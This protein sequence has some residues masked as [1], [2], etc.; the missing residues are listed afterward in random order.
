MPLHCGCPFR[1]ESL[2]GLFRPD[3]LPNAHGFAVEPRKNQGSDGGGLR[4]CGR[5][6]DSVTLLP[7]SKGQPPDMVR[8]AAELGLNVFG[9]NRVQ[10]AKAR[11]PCVPT[12][13]VGI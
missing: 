11:S 9:E 2:A 13:C 4:A 7:V 5:R 1:F 6:V 12:G 8:A 3:M 10:E